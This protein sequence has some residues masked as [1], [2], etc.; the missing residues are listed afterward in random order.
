MDKPYN[1]ENAA[2]HR[3]ELEESNAAFIIVKKGFF[4]TDLPKINQVSASFL[5]LTQ[6]TLEEC[7][8]QSWDVLQA[9]LV[10]HQRFLS[11][12]A[13]QGRDT[14]PARWASLALC[15]ATGDSRLEMMKVQNML[16][17]LC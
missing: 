11:V 9:R 1:A 16:A 6:F 7:I 13:V 2:I 17:V 4:E 12:V 3:K 10:Q 8:E 5:E 15:L 14:E